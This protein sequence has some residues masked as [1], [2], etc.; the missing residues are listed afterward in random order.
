[1]IDQQ[2]FRSSKYQIS[3]E[4]V[5]RPGAAA[6]KKPLADVVPEE[7]Q[8]A[9]S[10]EASQEASK[11]G[12]QE[13]A[14]PQ[15]IGKLQMEPSTLGGCH[16]DLI[17]RTNNNQPEKMYLK[18]VLFLKRTNH[19]KIWVWNIVQQIWINF[20]GHKK[21]EAK[22]LKTSS[23]EAVAAPSSWWFTSSQLL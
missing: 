12:S 9:E 19:T 2:A 16:E 11:Q 21:N 15:W 13:G 17:L 22:L 10:Q 7:S 8:D 18:Y 14:D 5:F 1:M 3:T 4:M 23:A 20:S 6:A